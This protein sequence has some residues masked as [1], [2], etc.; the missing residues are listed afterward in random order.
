MLTK[1]L[2][3]YKLQGDR[4]KPSFIDEE[5]P[6]HIDLARKLLSLYN[7][8]KAYKRSEIEELVG[9][10][11]NSYSDSI[12]AKGLNK[13]IPP[14]LKLM[15]LPCAKRHLRSPQLILKKI[16]PLHIMNSNQK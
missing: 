13:L 8:E 10:I 16:Y 5:N 3:K 7:P 12:M 9:P 15:L 14:R 2:L 11:L 1:N 6:D 4:V